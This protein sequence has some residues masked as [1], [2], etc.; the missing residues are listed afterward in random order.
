MYR[1]CIE[2]T[3]ANFFKDTFM[4]VKLRWI[5][6]VNDLSKSNLNNITD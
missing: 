5:L 3:L 2:C 4:I 1:T 6:K